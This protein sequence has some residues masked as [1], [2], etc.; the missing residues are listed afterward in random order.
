MVYVDTS[1]SDD[2]CSD[3]PVNRL[4]SLSI[5]SVEDRTERSENDESGDKESE[6][7]EV[8]PGKDS[9][10]VKVEL[11]DCSGDI[12]QDRIQLKR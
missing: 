7:E 10:V 4:R 2:A 12:G 1:R 11:T 3:L 9:G 6:P 5:A 8:V